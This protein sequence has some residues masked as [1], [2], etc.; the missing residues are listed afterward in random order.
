M[1]RIAL[2]ISVLASLSAMSGFLLSK[3]SLTGRVG[4]SLFYKKYRF[5]ETWWQG[6]LAV[7]AILLSLL[8][9]QGLAEKRFSKRTAGILHMAM[10][11]LAL[12]G[13]Y[14]TYHDFRHTTTHRLLGKRFHLGAYLFWIGWALISLFYLTKKPQPI[15]P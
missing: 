3:A 7:F 13:W 10:I 8:L 14:F 1:R 2:F 4:I 6:A 9:L 11:I 5:L 15:E 12:G